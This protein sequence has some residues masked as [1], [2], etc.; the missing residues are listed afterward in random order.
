M[1]QD[2][3]SW[4]SKKGTFSYSKRAREELYHNRLKKK[5][6][7]NQQLFMTCPYLKVYCMLLIC[8]C[9]HGQF[10]DILITILHIL[11]AWRFILTEL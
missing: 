5:P 6:S 1:F 10:K 4:K 11:A 3:I 2:L 8:M 7:A 9:P